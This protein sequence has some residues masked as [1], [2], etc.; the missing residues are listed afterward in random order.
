MFLQRGEVQWQHPIPEI[1]KKISE[2]IQK[3]IKG[4]KLLEKHAQESS[5]IYAK[6]AMYFARWMPKSISLHRISCYIRHVFSLK[7]GEFY[8]C[9]KNGNYRFSLLFFILRK[10]GKEFCKTDCR[11][12]LLD[13]PSLYRGDY[14]S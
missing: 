2:N 4:S 8:T 12:G 11:F 1:L 5:H 7:F 6:L 9:T 13:P 14:L 10:N 3:T